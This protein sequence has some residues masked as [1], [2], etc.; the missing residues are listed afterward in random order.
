MVLAKL[1]AE[2]LEAAPAAVAVGNELSEA[3]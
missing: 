3:F 1:S 2:Q